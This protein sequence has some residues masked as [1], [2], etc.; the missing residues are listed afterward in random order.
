VRGDRERLL[1]ILDAIRQIEKYAVRG[2]QAFEDDELLQTWV[3]YHLQIVGEACRMLSPR[4][5][6]R[7]P[8]GSWA[9]AAGMRNILIH[10]YFGIDTEAVWSAVEKDL[11]ELQRRVEAILEDLAK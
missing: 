4:L 5:R 11:P 1:D 6:E 9:P 8:E 10:H 3:I 2:R 7:Y